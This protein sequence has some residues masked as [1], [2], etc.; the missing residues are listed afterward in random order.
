ME[1]PSAYLFVNTDPVFFF[2]SRRRHTRLQG[3]WSSDVCSSDLIWTEYRPPKPVLSRAT[4]N[5]GGAVVTGAEA[6][7][8]VAAAREK[9]EV[10]NLSGTNLRG[11]N[12]SYADLSY[13]NLSYADLSR[14]NLSDADLGSADLS[15]ANL[16]GA[17]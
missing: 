6:L 13:A 8:I 7:A 17:N 12:L 16:I 2:S 10:P 11:T 1:Y 3:D 15:Y 4:R 9:G 14:A 5:Q